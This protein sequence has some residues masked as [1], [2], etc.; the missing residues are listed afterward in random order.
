M[1]LTEPKMSTRAMLTTAR[2]GKK[3]RASFP[4]LVL[5]M[6]R[7]PIEHGSPS[8]LRKAELVFNATRVKNRVAP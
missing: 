8:P 7:T 1:T 6:R 4:R 3:L 2:A 5:Y